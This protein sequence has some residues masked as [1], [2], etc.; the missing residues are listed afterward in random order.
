MKISDILDNL[1]LK[2]FEQ[3]VFL[4][5]L[6]YNEISV[7]K[8]SKVLAKPRSTIYSCVEKLKRDQFILEQQSPSG[9]IFSARW[10]KELIAILE[11]KKKSLDRMALN[12]KQHEYLFSEYQYLDLNAPKVYVYYWLDA[13]EIIQ[14][15]NIKEFWWFL[16][17]I[18]VLQKKL[19]WTLE[20]I[21]ESFLWYWTYKS[22]SIMVNSPLAREYKD[23]VKENHNKNHKIK[24]LSDDIKSLASD[25]MLMDE[26]YIHISYNEPMTAIEVKNPTFFDVQKI[27]FDG[28]RN[29][30][31]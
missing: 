7:W 21:I 9:A 31:K 28:L 11:K 29:S 20:N 22:K 15:S 24:F 25:T 14:T 2:A 12:I 13:I 4:I 3:E 18:D 17:D 30:L 8:I 23:Y 26:K 10:P 19:N 5:I 6:K 16:R 27:L 1:W